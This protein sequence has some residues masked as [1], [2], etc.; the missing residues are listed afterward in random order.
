MFQLL[1]ILTY[2]CIYDKESKFIVNLLSYWYEVNCRVFLSTEC[3]LKYESTENKKKD[4]SETCVSVQFCRSCWCKAF[5]FSRALELTIQLLNLSRGSCDKF[6][7]EQHF[8]LR[9][10]ASSILWKSWLGCITATR[11]TCDN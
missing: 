5:L 9:F 2:L 8:F 7:Q 6:I 11:C 3:E 1:L 10:A 4:L